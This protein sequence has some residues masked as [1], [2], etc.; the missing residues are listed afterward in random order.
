MF[1]KGHLYFTLDQH[2][3]EF[4]HQPIST[5]GVGSL[6]WPPLN[7]DQHTGKVTQVTLK[8]PSL[9]PTN[10]IVQ[11][12]LLRERSATSDMMSL[13]FILDK[14][15]NDILSSEIRK[16]GTIP[17]SYARKYP[18]IP[19][20]EYVATFPKSVLI[21]SPDLAG[22]SPDTQLP[23]Q[24][25]N[26]SPNGVLIC[27]KHPAAK[28]LKPNSKVELYFEPQGYFPAAVEASGIVRRA[29]DELSIK[30]G[31]PEINRHL[32]IQFTQLSDANREVF[33]ELLKDILTQLKKSFPTS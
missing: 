17:S 5:W 6:P 4:I 30:P 12:M 24:V 26:L 1:I 31:D 33:M 27:S 3:L 14:K 18:R 19:L 16:Y 2:T 10:L 21:R 13:K 20:T 25:L 29:M 23:F 22:V 32:G 28:L 15:N 9:G 7:P 11:A 8:I